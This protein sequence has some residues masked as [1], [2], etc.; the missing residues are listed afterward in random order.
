MVRRIMRHAISHRIFQEPEKGYVAHT[1]ASK[2]LAESND[3][4]QWIGMG[5][6]EMWP[7][8]TKAR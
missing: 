2:L 6:E 7:A 8:A 5:M 3:M 4:R 1:G